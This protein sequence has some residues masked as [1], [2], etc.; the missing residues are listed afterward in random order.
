MVKKEFFG[1]TK[2]GEIVD[3][4][5]ITDGGFSASIITFGATLQSLLIP[6]KKG[7]LDVVLG[8]DTVFEYE[9][10]G[11]YVGATIGRNSNRIK[12]GKFTFNGKS[13]ALAV[14]DNGKSNLHGGFTGFSHKVFSVQNYNEF[15]NSVTFKIF[16]PDGEENFPSNVNAQV[17]YTLE[18]GSLHLDYYGETDGETV[19]NM[20]NHSY[21][22]LDGDLSYTAHDNLLKIYGDYF[23]ATDENLIPTG[24]ILAVKNTPFDFTE[25]KP[26]NKDIRAE[27]KYIDIMQGYDLNYCL[28][29]R[30]KYALAATVKSLSTGL[31]MDVFTDQP[32]IQLYT[33]A[34][35]TERKGKRQ[36]IYKPNTSYCLETQV[37]PDGLNHPH[38]PS[39]FIDKDKP[40][41]TRTTY[42]FTIE[43]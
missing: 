10:N 13:Y 23:T 43:D 40:Y 5:T 1:K 36:R 22:T 15:S 12:D 19:L 26:I 9:N 35:L 39:P 25:F 41:K 31:I 4:Y 32:G 11:G 7:L 37:Y 42:K 16:S 27:N 33:G 14:N 34:Y 17:T 6:T 20:T 2:C 24:E 3:K 8:Y 29:N 18:G 38:F 21:F 28:N 30:K